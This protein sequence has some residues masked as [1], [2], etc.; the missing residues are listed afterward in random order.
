VNNLKN[1]QMKTAIREKMDS[2]GISPDAIA[3][4][5]AFA[6]GQPANVDVGDIVV[7]PSA[8]D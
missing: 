6:I 8:Q 4:A 3:S 1:E 7:R 2:L 5:V